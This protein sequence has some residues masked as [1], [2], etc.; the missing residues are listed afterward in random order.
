M[1]K[2]NVITNNINWLNYIK[3]PNY[4]LDQK[5]NKL[6][7]KEK[8]LKKYFIFHIIALRRCRNKISK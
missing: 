2:I 6:N 8:K 4:Y 7:L 1:I 3:K 5:I